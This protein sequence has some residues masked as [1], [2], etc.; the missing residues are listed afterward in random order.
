M[1]VRTRSL[2]GLVHTGIHSRGFRTLP[3]NSIPCIVARKLI[4]VVEVRHVL[5]VIDLAKD[6]SPGLRGYL[7]LQGFSG[8][9]ST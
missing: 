4:K 6:G 2:L 1:H 3:G 7:G 9:T 5:D 8:L